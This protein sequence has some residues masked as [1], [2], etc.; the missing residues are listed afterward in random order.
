VFHLVGNFYIAKSNVIGHEWTQELIM[1]ASNIDHSGAA[2]G[3]SQYTSYNVGMALLPTPFVLLNTPHIQYIS[4]QIQG[5]AGVVFEK[6][7]ELLGLGISCAQVN[8]G[9]TDCAISLPH[10]LFTQNSV[11]AVLHLSHCLGVLVLEAFL[12]KSEPQLFDL[13]KVVLELGTVEF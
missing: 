3:M 1:I 12:E 11:T 13:D 2:F 4:Y 10:K 6:V 8:I 5:F 9:Y 7:I